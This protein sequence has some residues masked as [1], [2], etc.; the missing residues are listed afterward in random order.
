MHLWGCPLALTCM[1]V[2]ISFMSVALSAVF[3][4]VLFAVGPLVS[5]PFNCVSNRFLVPL[6]V[7]IALWVLNGFF[8]VSGLYGQNADL[9]FSPIYCSLAFRPLLYF[10]V[11]TLVNHGFRWRARYWG[12]FVPVLLQAGLYWWLCFQPCTVRKDSWQHVHRLYTYRLEF[13]CTWVSLMFYTCC[14]ARAC[15]GNTATGWKTTSRKYY[16]GGGV[17]CCCYWPW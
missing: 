5:T 15:C 9:Y 10:Y 11:R 1:Q 13:I 3:A 12:H 4:Q 17:G 8:W 16:G 14:C 7:A 2:N 6:M